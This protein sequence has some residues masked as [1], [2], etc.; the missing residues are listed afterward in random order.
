MELNK[1]TYKYNVMKINDNIKSI[2]REMSLIIEKP[3]HN[4]AFDGHIKAA[5]RNLEGIE[6]MNFLMNNY[7]QEYFDKDSRLRAFDF[8][9]QRDFYNFIIGDRLYGMSEALENDNVSEVVSIAKILENELSIILEIQPNRDEYVKYVY[10]EITDLWIK[11][12]N[13]LP[14]SKK[15]NEFK[16]WVKF[17]RF[18]E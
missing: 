5:Q 11:I 16:E 10:D 9:N 18:N 7:V 8:Y 14:S 2:K 3:N 17:E 13:E 12:I 15:L 1:R 6:N 4:D